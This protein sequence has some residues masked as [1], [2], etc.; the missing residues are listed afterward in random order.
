MNS[1]QFTSGDDVPSWMLDAEPETPGG[2]RPTVKF[3]SDVTVVEH[4]SAY[5]VLP[6]RDFRHDSGILIEGESAEPDSD[7]NVKIFC[8][9]KSVVF[10]VRCV[11]I[12]PEGEPGGENIEWDQGPGKFPPGPRGA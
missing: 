10:L 1:W 7:T 5:W 9:D 6:S 8:A 4:A 2:P 3:S 12:T 11:A